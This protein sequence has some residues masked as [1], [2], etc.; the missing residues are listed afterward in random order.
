MLCLCVA[1]GIHGQTIKNLLFLFCC[2][3]LPHFSLWTTLI[4]WPEWFIWRLANGKPHTHIEM[5]LV[6]SSIVY[7]SVVSIF[8]VCLLL[9]LLL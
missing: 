1:G 8:L 9:L 3:L 2:C 4:L 6:L 5:F 7:V